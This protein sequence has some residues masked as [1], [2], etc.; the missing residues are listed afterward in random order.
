VLVI[1]PVRDTGD[2]RLLSAKQ[3]RVHGI[4]AAP[5]CTVWSYARNRYPPSIDEQLASLSVVDACLR[6]VAVQRPRWWALENPRNKLRAFL[7]AARLEFYQWEYGDA[8]HKPTCIWGDFSVPLKR[9]VRRSKP[10]TYK[11]SKPNASPDD[12]ITPPGFARAFYE[13]NP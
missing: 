6:V 7:G 10:T 8:G 11:T 2:V 9:P 3:G 1:D 4:L 13:V 12:A 5:P